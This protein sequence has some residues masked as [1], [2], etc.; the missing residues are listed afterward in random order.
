MVNEGGKKTITKY[1]KVLR[2]VACI[3]ER[4]QAVKIELQ[5]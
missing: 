3:L 5:S 1:L 2:K 4:K